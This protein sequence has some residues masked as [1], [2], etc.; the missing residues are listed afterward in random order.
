MSERPGLHPGLNSLFSFRLKKNIYSYTAA[1][2]QCQP[3]EKVTYFHDYYI[4]FPTFYNAKNEWGVWHVYCPLLSG[5]MGVAI[6][7]GPIGAPTNEL[8][9]LVRKV[10]L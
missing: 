7:V 3:A 1:S 6:N 9:Q 10:T 2:A 8:D 4:C 5:C